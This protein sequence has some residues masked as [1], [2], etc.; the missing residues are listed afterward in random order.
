M[1]QLIED[2]AS[3][4]SVAVDLENVAA[5]RLATAS[6][7]AA[8]HSR[9]RAVGH[10]ISPSILMPLLDLAGLAVVGWLGYEWA[11]DHAER[12]KLS[13]LDQGIVPG[14]FT[15]ATT[16]CAVLVCLTVHALGGYRAETLSRTPRGTAI[17][18]VGILCV[19]GFLFVLEGVGPG[20]RALDR[21]L[22]TSSAIAIP[23]LVLWRI[24]AL[25]LLAPLLPAK[26]R[27]AVVLGAGSEAQRFIEHL[28]Q[29]HAPRPHILGC[30]D[31]RATRVSASVCGVQY[32][33]NVDD[34]IEFVRQHTVDEVIIA[35][36]WSAEERLTALIERVKVLPVD[37]RLTP[38]G[39]GYRIVV[40]EI[41]S[42]GGGLPLF[43]AV[44]RP[45]STSEA[46]V[47]AIEDWL[48]G[49]GLLLLF[50]PI[51]AVIA[52]AIR[53]DSPGPIFFRQ[54]R[55]GW[56][57]RIIQV[58]KFR[59][60]YHGNSDLAGSRQTARNDERITRIGR[61]L[62]R[63][64]LDEIPQV[65][66]V[67]FGEMSVVGPRPHPIGMKTEEKL[68][69]EIVG[70]YAQRHKMKP[71]ITGWAQIHGWR[72]AT[73]SGYHLRKRVEH[74]IYYVENWSL[75]LDMKIL[76][77]TAFKGFRGPNAF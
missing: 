22:A 73:D 15:A 58:Y 43:T 48:V 68:C 76:V 52:L 7:A 4:P 40:P 33:G 3:A 72:G 65:I 9:P 32:K 1:A 75:W 56:N 19:A 61:F 10:V 60:M 26:A 57:N 51:M 35:L 13:T 41:S 53:L 37:I 47:K 50:F 71:G 34:L 49:A 67:L 17:A 54:P 42:A 66:N 2:G 5:P 6:A 11:F 77:M 70:G 28:Y 18:V 27:T 31:D 39:F 59:T 8:P 36:P 29:A 21:W 74:D 38:Y 62:R 23:A 20:P 63:T 44:Q 24:S 64:S 12:G 25:H 55:H 14:L 45:L 46:V 30:F 69:H 16:L